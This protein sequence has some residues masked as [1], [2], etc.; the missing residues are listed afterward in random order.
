MSIRNIVGVWIV[1]LC[2]NSCNE[3]EDCESVVGAPRTSFAFIN[4][5]LLAE[6]N[7]S[8]SVLNDSIVIRTDAISFNDS[9][10]TILSDSLDSIKIL[11]DSGLVEF[12][13]DSL[14]LSDE[15]AE[16]SDVNISLQSEA[17]S[18]TEI[19]TEVGTEIALVESGSVLVDTITSLI[20]NTSILFTDSASVYSLPLE[21]SSTETPYSFS[22]DGN[23][24]ELNLTYEV[25]Q[26]LNIEREVT[27]EAFNVGVSSH[28]FDSLFIQC[29]TSE[30]ISNETGIICYF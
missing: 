25:R 22:I 20:Q 10:I 4:G 23:Q 8:I 24:Y 7:D 3:C 14:L 30:C 12:R 2:M 28:T 13:Q 16:L 18:I 29:S 1:L 6:L 17:D 5:T 15:I 26:S 19:S 27:I 9:I 11:L 21:I